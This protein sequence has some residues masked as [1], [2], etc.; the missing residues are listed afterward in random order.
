MKPISPG[1]Q[2]QIRDGDV[3]YR[4]IFRDGSLQV[5][6]ECGSGEIL[7]WDTERQERML[8]PNPVGIQGDLVQ[9]LAFSPDGRTLAGGS[10]DGRVVLW[11]LHDVSGT[12]PVDIVELLPMHTR[13]VNDLAFSEDGTLLVSSS[14][15]SL[16][17]REC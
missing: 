1:S 6:D 4:L 16:D 7:F 8:D 5:Y 17:I 11:T 3:T 10:R 14:C 12:V 15:G 9:A 13:A 2:W